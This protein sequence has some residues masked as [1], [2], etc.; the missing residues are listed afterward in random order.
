MRNEMPQDK[1]SAIDKTRDASQFVKRQQVHT[2]HE[3]SDEDF[4]FIREIVYKLSRISI[5]P[6]KR[7]MVLS[8]ISR[9]MR[10][11][12]FSSV[13]DYC[14]YIKKPTGSKEL[15]ALI[16]AISTNHTYFFREA[17]HFSYLESV[18]LQN[19]IQQTIKPFKVWSAASSSGEEPYSLGMALMEHAR[20]NTGFDWRMDATDISTTVLERAKKAV[21]PMTSLERVPEHYIKN[22]CNKNT[23]EDNFTVSKEIQ[24]RIQFQQANL[25]ELPPSLANDYDLIVCRNV[26]IYFDRPTREQL[27]NSLIRRLKT[28]GT[29]F[30]GHSE[31]LNGLQHNLKMIRPAIYVKA[32]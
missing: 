11:L 21:Y 17:Q 4:N 24:R 1:K 29:L 25:F 30:V 15:S 18:I 23:S 8:R 10:A 3:A 28:D 14:D 27:I 26:M 7:V 5:G 32:H 31:S 16:D 12:Q 19:R 20:S 9:R 22:H 2:K 13:K 6:N